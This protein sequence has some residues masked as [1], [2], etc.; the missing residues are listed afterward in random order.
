MPE[1]VMVDHLEKKQNTLVVLGAYR[2]SMVSRW[3]KAS[4]ADLLIKKTQL[5]LF[6]A[7]YK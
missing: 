2:R 3:F 1:A 6:I 4:M 7:H 5:P